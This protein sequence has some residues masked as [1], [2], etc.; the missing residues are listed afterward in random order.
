MSNLYSPHRYEMLFAKGTISIPYPLSLIPRILCETLF[1]SVV[2]MILEEWLC[3]EFKNDPEIVETA[4]RK[5]V[6]SL[7]Y[8]SMSLHPNRQFAIKLVRQM[9]MRCNG[10]VT[11]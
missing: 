3:D 4:V 5:A 8:A 1:L 10:L 9:G 11:N 7:L 6:Y 2:C